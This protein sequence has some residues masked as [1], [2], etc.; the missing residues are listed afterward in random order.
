MGISYKAE[1]GQYENFSISEVVDTVT[2]LRDNLRQ[3]VQDGATEEGLASLIQSA[4]LNL[5]KF[6][7]IKPGS[8]RDTEFVHQATQFTRAVI[9]AASQKSK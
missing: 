4:E 2:E 5:K 6:E 8:S 9:Q 1:V 3:K 7:N